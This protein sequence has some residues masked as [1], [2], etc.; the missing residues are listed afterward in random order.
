MKWS[1]HCQI[2]IIVHIDET[3]HLQVQLLYFYHLKAEQTF[4]K[5]LNV[6]VKRKQNLENKQKIQIL[7]LLLN[8]TVFAK[9][10]ISISAE[11]FRLTYCVN[12]R[13]SERL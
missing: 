4:K 2:L 9:F 7:P 10:L 6:L 13:A 1:C 5:V 11:S 8:P 12:R 3:L